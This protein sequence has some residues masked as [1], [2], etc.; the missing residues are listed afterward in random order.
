MLE[1]RAYCDQGHSP[2]RDGVECPLSGEGV[3]LLSGVS[4][5]D[6]FLSLQVQ[7]EKTKT[8]AKTFKSIWVQER[9]EE[10]KFPGWNIFHFRKSC[11]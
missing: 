10:E 7:T 8:K 1:D 9:K 11:E 6:M 2:Q 4:I 5:R 3:C